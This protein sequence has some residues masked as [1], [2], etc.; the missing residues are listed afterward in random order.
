MTSPD[1]GPAQTQPPEDLTTEATFSD[2]GVTAQLVQ[3]LTE[4][5]ITH[6]FPIQEMSIPIT[7]SGA[8]LILY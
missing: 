4:V 8:D 7:L 5:G 6:P 1:N 2:L 3:A